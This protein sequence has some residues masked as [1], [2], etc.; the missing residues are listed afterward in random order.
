MDTYKA[1]MEIYINGI[2]KSPIAMVIKIC[3]RIDNLRN[4]ADKDSADLVEKYILESIWISN[5]LQKIK[6]KKFL[7]NVIIEELEKDFIEALRYAESVKRDKEKQN[8]Q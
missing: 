7:D 3:D 6:E 5:I 1:D 4:I 2:C 8:G